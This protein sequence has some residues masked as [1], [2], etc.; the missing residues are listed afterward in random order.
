LSVSIVRLINSNLLD[1]R[2]TRLLKQLKE[3]V[4]YCG[5]YKWYFSSKRDCMTHL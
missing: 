3:E 5:I 4:I 2:K 1:G